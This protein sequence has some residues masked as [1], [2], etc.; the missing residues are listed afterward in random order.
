M[1]SSI[2]QTIIQIDGSFCEGGG[3]LLRNAVTLSAL[4]SK[5]ISISNVRQ[6]RRPPGLRRQHEAGTSYPSMRLAFLKHLV[7]CRHKPCSIDLFCRNQGSGSS[8]H[9]GRLPSW[10]H[11]APQNADCRPRD[12]R[13]HD[14]PPSGSP[15]LP[16]VQ[17]SARVSSLR[18]PNL[19]RRSH[20][21]VRPVAPW[22][23]KRLARPAN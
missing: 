18:V 8:F 20:C 1:T 6:N 14:T 3:Q 21:D 9:S 10:S 13:L 16:L 17:P 12:S 11:P 4:L 7:T 15:P 22:R 2:A 5:P 19:T 23:H